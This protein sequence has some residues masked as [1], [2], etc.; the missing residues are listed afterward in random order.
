ML[1]STYLAE[2]IQKPAVTL[3]TDIGGTQRGRVGRIPTARTE[4]VAKGVKFLAAGT[5]DCRS[6]GSY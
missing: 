3:S 2:D 1:T 5:K 4:Q 6:M